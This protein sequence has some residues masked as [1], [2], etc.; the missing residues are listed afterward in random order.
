MTATPEVSVI[1]ATH[2]RRD[3]LPATIAGVVAQSGVPWELIVVDD[4]SDDGTWRYL[5]NLAD[6][7]LTC[8]RRA[9]VGL[10]AMARNDGLALARGRFVMF[11]DDDDLLRPGALRCLARGLRGHP[12]AVAA[13]GARW[14]WFC[15]GRG[16]GRRDSHPRWP[17]QRRI[18]RDLI[19]GWSA[20]SGQNLYRAEVARAVGGYDADPLVDVVEDRD[21]WL[22]VAR[23]GPVLLLPEIVMSYRVHPSQYRPADL[24]QRRERVYRRA[25][26]RFPAPLRRAALRDRL[27]SRQIEEAERM[28]DRGDIR[29]ACRTA[30][31]AWRR[32][33]A[34]FLSPLIGPWVA[35][36]LLRRVWHSLRRR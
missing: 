25:L 16:G 18:E 2:N 6:P 26:R 8:R 4:A 30:A 7:R 19:F 9:A 24:L 21:F 22:R 31:A 36:R 10:A 33:P 20:V 32:S 29:G 11:L 17:R 15:D 1:I 23:H 3:L 27:A 14:D 5:E 13:V 28:I 35:R 34:I 12:A